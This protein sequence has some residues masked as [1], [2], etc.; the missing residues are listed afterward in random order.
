V[1]AHHMD[2]MRHPFYMLESTIDSQWVPH[3]LHNLH[4]FGHM[5]SP[6]AH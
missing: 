6:S 3:A 1:D 5:T 2:N 4:I